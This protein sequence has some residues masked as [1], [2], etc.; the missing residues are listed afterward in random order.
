[1]AAARLHHLE[2]DRQVDRHRGNGGAGLGHHGLEHGHPGV[3][4]LCR[5][6]LANA[7]HAPV[8]VLL[9][10]TDGAVPVDVP[11]H[12]LADVGV[13]RGLR[14]LGQHAG[15]IQGIDPHLPVLAT[16]D[17]DGIVDL[18]LAGGLQVEI[19]YFLL[20]RIDALLHRRL[21]DRLQGGS[22]DDAGHRMLAPR[23]RQAV[24]HQVDLAQ[25]LAD[26]GYGLLLDL[27]AEGVAVDAFRVQALGL[28]SAVEGGAV[29]P[30]GGTRLGLGTLLLEENPQGGGAGAKGRGD[31]RGQA[32]AG[33][34]ADH[35]HALRTI[36]DGTV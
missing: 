30:A 34:G 15:L 19:L 23:R 8:Q 20:V 18:L 3:T 10:R 24:D 11:G 22:V 14:A 35:Q 25:V 1:M 21:A 5:E 9:G 7:D 12:L 29:V 28:G 31:P 27:V 17:G 33:G 26:G 36:L 32:I 6:P 16:H 2:Q 13:G 4:A